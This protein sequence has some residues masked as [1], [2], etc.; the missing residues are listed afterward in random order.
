MLKELQEGQLE[1]REILDGLQ[2]GQKRIE[3]ELQG[4]KEQINTLIT[5]EIQTHEKLEQKPCGCK[6]RRFSYLSE[7]KSF[8]IHLVKSPDR[9]LLT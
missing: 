9:R 2:E 7:N 8:Y 4:V 1:L 3:N 5:Y 6:D